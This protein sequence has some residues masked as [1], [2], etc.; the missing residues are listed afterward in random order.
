MLS[1]TNR[2][3]GRP[4]SGLDHLKQSVADILN[5]PIGSRVIRRTYGSKLPRLIDAPWSPDLKLDVI[6]ATGEALDRWESRIEVTRVATYHTF[7]D[8]KAQVIVD[9]EGNY[10]PT[11]EPIKL[12]GIKIL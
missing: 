6:A 3:T 9:V 1:G 5:T 8:G 2:M 7:E 11:G 10:L 4:L 12:E